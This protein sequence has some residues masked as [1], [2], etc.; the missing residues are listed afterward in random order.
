MEKKSVEITPDQQSKKNKKVKFLTTLFIFTL[1]IAMVT[2]ALSGFFIYKYRTAMNELTVA[3]VELEAFKLSS[4]PT[5]ENNTSITSVE[6]YF[7]YVLNPEFCQK[8]RLKLDESVEL[9]FRDYKYDEGKLPQANQYDST[10]PIAYI[11]K[12]E[13]SGKHMVCFAVQYVESP[14]KH[15]VRYMY[16]FIEDLAAQLP[17]PATGAFIK[18]S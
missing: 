5:I 17:N 15:T 7:D 1:I 2:S 8:Y 16:V 18:V 9:H 13:A 14:E 10:F 11:E 4:L 12:D 3:T 6:Q